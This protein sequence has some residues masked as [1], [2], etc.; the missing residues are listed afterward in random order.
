MARRTGSVCRLCRRE[1]QKLF[2][3]GQRCNTAKCGVAVREYPPGER[4]RF[5]PKASDY[6]IRLREKQ[7]AKRMF[8]LMERQLRNYFQKA[9]GQ[10]GPTGVNLLVLLE[11]RLDNVVYRLGFAAGRVQARQLIRHGHFTVNGKKTDI[12]S[13]LLSAGDEVGI[14]QR[15]SDLAVFKEAVEIAKQREI[16]EWLQSDLKNLKGK[17]LRMPER[18]EMPDIQEQFIVELYSK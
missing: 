13:Y 17:V 16:P 2:L 14:K 1:K 11:R 7:K 4:S 3:K 12:P 5:A 6:Q 18:D 8:G 15:S 10:K 9:D